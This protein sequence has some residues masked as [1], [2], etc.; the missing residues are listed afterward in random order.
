MRFWLTTIIII[1]TIPICQLIDQTKCRRCEIITNFEMIVFS[2]Q[3]KKWNEISFSFIRSFFSNALSKN[4]SAIL[5]SSERH[6]SL[7]FLTEKRMNDYPLLHYISVAAS[8]TLG[9]WMKKSSKYFSRC[10]SLSKKVLEENKRQ[11]WKRL[12][13]LSISF[14]HK[15]L[16]SMWIQTTI[17]FDLTVNSRFSFSNKKCLFTS[18]HFVSHA[19]YSR[20]R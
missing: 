16:L 10:F 20:S 6:R 5:M 1:F 13:R 3:S 19:I 15:C 18:C 8:L 9:W 11:I 2:Q 14:S 4:H 12:L 17:V 7:S